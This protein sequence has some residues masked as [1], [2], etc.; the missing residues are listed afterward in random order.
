MTLRRAVLFDMCTCCRARRNIHST[1]MKPTP[2][3]VQRGKTRAHNAL[4][5]KAGD[6]TKTDTTSRPAVPP[7]YA[8]PYKDLWNLQPTKLPTAKPRAEQ[9][10]QTGAK[11]GTCSWPC[12]YP[13]AGPVLRTRSGAQCRERLGREADTQKSCCLM[14]RGTYLKRC[15]MHKQPKHASQPT[16]CQDLTQSTN[17]SHA[18]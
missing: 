14:H 7:A 17:K 16:G 6:E 10:T 2:C 15:S 5:R 8:P 3:L 4:S 1:P 18:N 12:S 11:M 9:K 13:G